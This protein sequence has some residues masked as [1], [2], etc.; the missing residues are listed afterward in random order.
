[1]GR[2]APDF[3][4]QNTNLSELKGR[5]VLLCFFNVYCRACEEEL[6]EIE[7]GYREANHSGAKFILIDVFQNKSFISEISQRLKLSF[8]ILP[9]SKGE[10]AKIYRVSAFP[11]FF[12][13]DKKGVVRRRIVGN[14]KME[15][16]AALMYEG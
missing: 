11:T 1:V 2:A 14:L 5:N 3:I 8:P 15:E 16:I 9:D 6:K 7:K 10:I 13:I 12:L 4:L